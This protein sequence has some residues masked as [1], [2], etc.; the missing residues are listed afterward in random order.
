MGGIN[1]SAKER[2]KDLYLNHGYNCAEAVWLA[3]NEN[4]LDEGC[5]NFGLKLAGGFG[6]GIG[7]GCLCGALAGAA[8][9]LGR[10]FGRE[11]GEERNP[12]LPEAEKALC[13]WFRDK[14]GSRECCDLK[15]PENH[16]PQCAEMIGAVVEF[17]EK[18]LDEGVPGLDDCG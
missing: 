2:A 17:T 3:L 14:Y 11:M 4:D 6:G 15:L 13:E 10:W 5:L 16:K 9:T 1:V 7:C 8:L 12:V 18:L